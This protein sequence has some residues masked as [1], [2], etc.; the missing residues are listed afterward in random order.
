MT[1]GER[2]TAL[3]VKVEHLNEK[4]DAAAK[5][6]DIM[7]DLMQQMRGAKWAIWT[8][9]AT[10]GMVVGFVADKL[11]KLVPFFGAR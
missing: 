6:I 4:L 8:L 9:L 11:H 2:I 3:E 7:H 10:G 1:D 5:K